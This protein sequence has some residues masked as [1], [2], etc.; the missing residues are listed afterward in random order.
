MDGFPR[1]SVVRRGA[2]ARK[3][4]E[5]AQGEFACGATSTSLTLHKDQLVRLEGLFSHVER[6][7]HLAYIASKLDIRALL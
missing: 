2:E 7:A 4:R 5:L 6:R 3:K 1:S